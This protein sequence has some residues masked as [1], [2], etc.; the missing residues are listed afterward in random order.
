MNHPNLQPTLSGS[1]LRLAPLVPADFDALYSVARDPLI[2]EQHPDHDRYKPDVFAAFFEKAIAS[3]GALLI[4]ELATDAVVGSS[5]YYDWNSELR[6]I[7]IGYTFLARRC[8]GGEFNRELKR[9]MIAHA[10][11]FAERIWFHVGS[12]NKRSRRALEKIGASFSH[13]VSD[14]S[15]WAKRSMAYYYVSRA[16]WPD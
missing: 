13:E 3:A 15:A 5:R 10:L 4:R 1:L 9:L 12:G 7:S 6:E 16:D 11:E 8:W 2:W 14:D